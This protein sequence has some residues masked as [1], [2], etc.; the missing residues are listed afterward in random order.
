MAPTFE[1]LT[2]PLNI[3]PYLNVKGKSYT[4]TTLHEQLKIYAKQKPLT[5]HLKINLRRPS[6]NNAALDADQHTF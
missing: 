3:E 1:V 5:S 2:L 6:R 4:F